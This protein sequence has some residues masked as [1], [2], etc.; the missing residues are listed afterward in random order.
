MGAS[1]E[2][3]VSRR[4]FYVICGYRGRKRCQKMH[5]I[6][7]T[8]QIWWRAET[9]W[10]NL[11]SIIH[12]ER[13]ITGLNLS[14]ASQWMDLTNPNNIKESQVLICKSW[15]QIMNKQTML[16]LCKTFYRPLPKP[17]KI[18]KLR[19]ISTVRIIWRGT[20]IHRLMMGDN[21]GTREIN[22]LVS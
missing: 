1:P 11:S 22:H 3:K 9:K 7:T 17:T 14:M 19:I 2:G 18:H 4:N 13:S 21:L 6:I 20:L 12:L 16:L 5:S 10:T 15:A 8:I